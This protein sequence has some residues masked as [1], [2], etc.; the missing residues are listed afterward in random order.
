MCAPC[1]KF[2]KVVARIKRTDTRN[3]DAM[4]IEFRKWIETL[5]YT[6]CRVEIN[7]V[8]EFKEGVITKLIDGDIVLNKIEDGFVGEVIG[9]YHLDDIDSIQVID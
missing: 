5:I 4:N 8:N 9:T 7:V 1:K 3:I 2:A 6:K